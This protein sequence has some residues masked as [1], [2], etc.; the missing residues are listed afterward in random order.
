MEIEKSYNNITPDYE[1]IFDEIRR[2]VNE[3]YI[4]YT[5]VIERNN[6]NATEYVS[7]FGQ[8]IRDH[9]HQKLIKIRDWIDY[10]YSRDE[11]HLGTYLDEQLTG[12][13][14]TLE[15]EESD[16][17]KQT[18]LSTTLSNIYKS[19]PKLENKIRHA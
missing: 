3:Y 16:T 19:L 10:K 17:I 5:N 13:E 8:I 9:V 11:K 18:C 6:G 2:N 7:I 1:K 12:L 15:S 4:R 14:K